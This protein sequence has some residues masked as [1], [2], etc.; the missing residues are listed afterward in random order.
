MVW[1][2]DKIEL[3][4]VKSMADE[5]E[6]NTLLTYSAWGPLQDYPSIYGGLWTLQ[7]MRGMTDI[8]TIA[9]TNGSSMYNGRYHKNHMDEVEWYKVEIF[10]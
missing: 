2:L 3:I 4:Y 8:M 7:I 5:I 9:L 10:I 1:E 6:Q